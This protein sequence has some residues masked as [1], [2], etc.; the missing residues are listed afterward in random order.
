MPHALRPHSSSGNGGAGGIVSR[1]SQPLS[2]SGSEGSSSRYHRITAAGVGE[3]VEDRARRSRCRARRSGGTGTSKEVTTPKLPPPPRRAQ[4]RSAC[5]DLAGGDER[6]VREHDVGGEQV[7]DGEAVAP[8]QVA[9]AAAEGQ[10]AHAGGRDEPAG[11][12]HAEAD[13]RVVD[14]APTCSRRPTRTV[15][16]SGSTRTPCIGDRSI[17]SASSQT[18]RP[19][20]LWPPPRTAISI[21]WRAGEPD[22]LLT[23][24]ASRHWA[25]AAGRLSIIAL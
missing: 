24:A 13:R 16:R 18:P 25:I 3:V 2:S 19:P 10:A 22:A 5:S 7:V 23:S 6:A 12:R 15:R 21:P 14:V 9:D 17:T 20:A 1:P 8:G 11:R 4:N